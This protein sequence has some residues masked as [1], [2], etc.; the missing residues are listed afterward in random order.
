[1]R[2]KDEE[3]PQKVKAQAYTQ[4]LCPNN[5]TSASVSLVLFLSIK[6]AVLIIIVVESLS[7]TMFVILV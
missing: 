7:C 6:I 2:N 5:H 1:M 4:A 3:F